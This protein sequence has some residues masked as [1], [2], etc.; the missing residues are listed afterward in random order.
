MSNSRD[1]NQVRQGANS[2]SP[3]RLAGLPSV[4]AM[5]DQALSSFLHAVKERLEVR[6][7]GRGNPFERAVTFRDLKT[8]GLS[9]SEVAF[10]GEGK[11]SRILV[12]R[13]GGF[14]AI[15]IDAFAEALQDTQAYQNLL[16]RLDNQTRF[17][18][19][20]D[21]VR[22]TL[23]ADILAAAAERGADIQRV[24]TKIQ[25]VETSIAI[26]VDEVTAA[27]NDGLA[28]VRDTAFAA[29]NQTRATAGRVTQLRAEL[30]GKVSAVEKGAT[31]TADRVKGL[32]GEYF[33]KVQAGNKLAGY[34]LAAS[35]DPAGNSESSFIVLA[36]KFA[37]VGADDDIPN[38]KVLPTNR[39]PFGVDTKTNTIFLNGNVRINAG[40][41]SLADT[42]NVLNY[43]GEFATAPAPA[44]Y[45]P[46]S[47]YR[48]TT[49]RNTYVR[50]AAGAWEVFI[51]PGAQGF[52]GDQGVPGNP[53]GPGPA[54]PRGSANVVVFGH[55]WSDEQADRALANVAGAITHENP[56]RVGDQVTIRDNE[57]FAQ[58]R[59]WNGSGWELPG[60]VVHGNTLVRGSLAAD[61]IGAD[62]IHAH[63]IRTHDIHARHIAGHQ[64]QAHHMTAGSITA[65][66][67]AIAHLAVDTFHI[68]GQAVT[69]PAFS[70]NTSAFALSTSWRAA[71]SV[72]LHGAGA[73]LYVK[74]GCLGNP[75]RESDA[76]AGAGGSGQILARVRRNHDIVYEG[77]VVAV[78]S[79]G[80]TGGHDVITLDFR[81]SHGFTGTVGQIH[82]SWLEVVAYKR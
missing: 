67:G 38:P 37:I 49:D 52:R 20:I 64:I 33:L 15:S 26:Q 9:G 7:G 51:P 25:D 63:H 44:N 46:N 58:T 81:D 35:E 5:P 55:N 19:L 8:L 72:G 80:S 27:V 22:H 73:P 14:D 16:K 29:V 34:S 18:G 65:E 43:V 32:A 50:N 57:N 12:P 54:G 2:T 74:M 48:N 82:R 75:S 66:N 56:R 59:Y 39:I 47:V 3:A 24:E 70:L 76:E 4:P 41:K 31:A 42:A 53:G 71:V 40:G 21:E 11:P 69:V 62:Q 77:P 79:F 78:F 23:L 17:D 30:E 13:N 36:D 60:V 1:R 45:P 10:D 6:E 68:R 61:R 28:G